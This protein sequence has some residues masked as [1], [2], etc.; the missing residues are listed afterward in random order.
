MTYQPRPNASGDTLSASR[1]QI[2]TNFEVIQDIFNNNH[3]DFGVAGEGKHAFLQMPEQ[4]APPTTAANEAGFYAQ[5]ANMRTALYFR[6]E[7]DGNEYQL[8][9]A[10]D[11]NILRFGTNL[12]YD[13]GPPAL[14]GG[15]TF[16]AGNVVLQYG[17]VTNI[18]VKG[19]NPTSV[20]FS[21]AFGSA[22]YSITIT[23]EKSGNNP[24]TDS[25][26]IKNGTVTASGFDIVT[27]DTS[28][29]IGYWMAI[30]PA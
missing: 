19:S 18:N 23:S 3:V 24:T 30:G 12:T 13:A 11:A 4:I 15:W 7:S 21:K 29:R 6:S 17:S 20:T 22:P 2:R 28:Q 27:T 1:D 16:L 8:T 5:L 26:H 25:I 10:D 9:A 14:A